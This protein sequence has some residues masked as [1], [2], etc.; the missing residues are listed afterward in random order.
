MGKSGPL[1]EPVPSASRDV[2]PPRPVARAKPQSSDSGASD[3]AVV[4]AES[5]QAAFS[6]PLTHTLDLT[7]S[8]IPR[9]S[10]IPPSGLVDVRQPRPISAP[11]R[12]AP[13]VAARHLPAPG[14]V[15]PAVTAPPLTRLPMES[16]VARK[17]VQDVRSSKREIT[18]GLVIG[19]GLS[20]LLGV[21]AKDYLERPYVDPRVSAHGA[22][23]SSDV[24]GLPVERT[25]AV[26]ST[27]ALSPAEPHPTSANAAERSEL[28][29][30]M[31]ESLA[32]LDVEA[33]QAEVAPKARSKMPRRPQ[34][35]RPR[36]AGS[37]AVTSSPPS[38]GSEPEPSRGPAPLSPSESAGLGLELPL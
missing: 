16:R 38:A 2:R 7:P 33:A 12:N 13:T 34:A 19:V 21:F 4:I 25:S 14:R 28:A 9:A 24:V 1:A 8:P 23:G 27:S 18:Y 10:L 20:V 11:E 15:R 3:D 31:S 32:A 22:A 29:T 17:L 26:E 30:R 37:R 36:A 6:E 35:S 5:P